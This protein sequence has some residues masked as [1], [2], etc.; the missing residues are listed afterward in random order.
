[1]VADITADDFVAKPSSNALDDEEA[2]LRAAYEQVTAEL[3]RAREKAS[4][5]ASKTTDNENYSMHDIPGVGRY[6][7]PRRTGW[8][9]LLEIIHDPRPNVDFSAN[10]YPAFDGI[11]GEH[12]QSPYLLDPLHEKYESYENLRD[13]L[14]A[15]RNFLMESYYATNSSGMSPA[16]AKAALAEIAGF[17]GDGLYNNFLFGGIIPNHD[18]RKPFIDLDEASEPNGHGAQY[19]YERI[20]AHQRHSSWLRPFDAVIALFGGKAPPDWNLPPAEQTHFTDEIERDIADDKTATAPL[21]AAEATV[22]AAAAK[23]AELAARLAAVADAKALSNAARDIDDIGNHL[24]Y[25]ATNMEGVAHLD[26]PVRQKAVEIARDILRKLKFSLGDVSV[27][28]GLKMKPSDDMAALGAIKGVATVYERLLAWA[29]SNNDTAIFQHPSVIA[30]TRAI[31]QLGYTAKREA[32]RLAE[33]SGNGKLAGT[34]REQ[35]KRLPESF[36]PA[37]GTSMGSLLDKVQSGIDVVMNRTQQVS[38]SGGQ[39][40]HSIDGNLG[41]SMSAN[42]TAGI[43][44][45]AG[46]EQAAKRNT[47][48]MLADQLSAQAQANRIH[49]Q[50]AAQ[51]HQSQQTASGQ[52]APAKPAPTAP[53]SGSTVGRQ[54]LNAARTRQTAAPKVAP[55]AVTPPPVSPAQQQAAQRSATSIALA[56]AA[57][58]RAEHEQHEHEAQRQQQLRNQ[59]KIAAQSKAK[60]AVT[61]IDPGLLKGFQS[62]TSLQGVTGTPITG[63]RK[64]DPQAVRA[65]A[66][67][68]ATEAERLKQQQLSPQPPTPPTRGGGRGF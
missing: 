65:A 39:V 54:A 25:T 1:M 38:V 7:I 45:Q 36:T 10:I 63:G 67:K 6:V 48:A 5:E 60:A 18:P 31:G 40:G 37:A 59:Q 58:E 22:A 53:R 27:L 16:Q 32:L 24:V 66:T 19:I 23:Q 9:A 52:S 15:V 2:G 57:Q 51:A 64:I 14:A 61:G 35:I 3:T 44:N 4:A 50:L 62:A 30:A 20:L 11:I 55:T 68:A 33:L 28:D 8:K 17:V 56:R 41:S 47:Q 49:G 21:D 34:L 13:N 46:A 43:G 26:A 29:R 12:F 42:P